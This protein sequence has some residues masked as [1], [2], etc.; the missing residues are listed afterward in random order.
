MFT[1]GVPG[2]GGPGIPVIVS[3]G[4]C[5]GR[6]TPSL[7]SPPMERSDSRSANLSTASAPEA[8]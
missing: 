6:A 8:S 3:P 5:V 1:Q 7:T 4:R 2:Y